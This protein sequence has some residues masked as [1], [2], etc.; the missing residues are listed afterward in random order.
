MRILLTVV[1]LVAALGAVAG[2]TQQPQRM[3]VD[4]IRPAMLSWRINTTAPAGPS[5]MIET[6]TRA[7]LRDRQVWRVTHYS[8]DPT[9]MPLNDFDMY[10]VAADTLTPI[11]ST[12]R[13]SQFSL[14][15]AFSPTG[16]T[17]QR[18]ENGEVA[19][20]HVPLN[21]AVTPE[22]PGW[23]VVLAALPLTV[24]FTRKFHMVDRL[25]G[26][27]AGRL[28]ALT[29]TVLGRRER[30][31][32]MGSLAAFEVL[33]RADDGSFQLRD[34]VRATPPHYPFRTEYNRGSRA[35]ISEVTAMAIAPD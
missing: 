19:T 13:T 12:M 14:D 29:L 24:E 10:D 20:D 18:Q 11:R 30:M 27:G 5:L 8:A 25:S 6:V 35:V 21:V 1:T 31:T 17:H 26:Q 16:V 32:P 7:M 15:L 33:T 28:K 2:G 22:G 9:A 3:V 4:Q 23:T 34:F